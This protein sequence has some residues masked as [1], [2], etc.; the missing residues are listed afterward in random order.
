MKEYKLMTIEWHD[1]DA[2]TLKSL[3][4]TLKVKMSDFDP[5]FDIVLV[6]ELN[7]TYAFRINSALQIDRINKDGIQGPFSDPLIEPFGLEEE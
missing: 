3:S 1:G 7:N 5:Q 2:P 6:N 4:K